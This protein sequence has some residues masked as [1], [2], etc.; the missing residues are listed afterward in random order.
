MRGCGEPRQQHECPQARSYAASTPSEGKAAHRAVLRWL[1]ASR[2]VSQSY[3][4]VPQPCSRGRARP[5]LPRAPCPL[6]VPRS[7]PPLSNC[8][9]KYSRSIK[10]TESAWLFALDAKNGPGRLG[11]SCVM[12]N[13]Q[14]LPAQPAINQSPAEAAPLRV[15]AAMP[16]PPEETP[17]RWQMSQLP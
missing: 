1:S 12:E 2:F 7:H 13:P 5:R 16:P 11:A 8:N 15:A 17:A 10:T 3:G 4:R 6:G 14:H 9:N